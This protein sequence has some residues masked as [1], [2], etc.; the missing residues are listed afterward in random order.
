[1]NE[2][3]ISMKSQIGSSTGK[4]FTICCYNISL[5]VIHFCIFFIFCNSIVMSEHKGS[6]W[7]IFE[8]H[9]EVVGMKL[10]SFCI[11]MAYV[12]GIKTFV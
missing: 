10:T 5:Y 6:W 4:R 3:I 9:D 11:F 12:T 8:V 1:M 7:F 2:L